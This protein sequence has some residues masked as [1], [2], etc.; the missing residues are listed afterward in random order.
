MSAFE[1]RQWLAPKS[2][3]GLVL[4]VAALC[5]IVG[6][7][8]TGHAQGPK[9]GQNK[10]NTPKPGVYLNGPL[11]YGRLVDVWAVDEFDNPT[12]IFK[13]KGNFFVEDPLYV[14]MVVGETAG[15]S[16]TLV[17]S[18]DPPVSLTLT[19]DNVS[20]VAVMIIGAQYEKSSKSRFQ[21]A[22][23]EIQNDA[24][25]VAIGGVNALPPYS[26]VP[27]DAAIVLNFDRALNP[28]SIGP[29]SIRFYVGNSTTTGSLPPSPFV[30]RYIWKPELPKQVIFNPSI[31]PIDDA[32]ITTEIDAFNLA[33]SKKANF[34][35][36]ILP[37]NP[38]GLP[39]SVA[40]TS[41]NVAVFIPAEYNITAGVTKILLA[42]DG[43]AIDTNKSLT[44]FNLSASGAGVDGILGVAR[45]FRSGGATDASQGFLSDPTVPELL[46]TQGITI[47]SVTSSQ[48]VGPNDSRQITF[49]YNNSSCDLSV[50]VGDSIQQ[51]NVFAQ[52]AQIFSDS[53]TDADPSYTV[54]VNYF[55][56]D[57]IF[58][59]IDPAIIT[60]PY[61]TGLASKS[62]CF[63]SI[64]PNPATVGPTVSGVDPQTT[65]TVRFSK[66]MDFS[67]VNPLR[68]FAITSNTAISTPTAA[69][70]FELI[71]G[72][73]IPS[74]DLKALK[75]VPYLPLPHTSGNT[76][77]YK[78]I[79][80]DGAKGVTDIVGN[81]LFLG[82]SGLNF[83]FALNSVAPSNSS[84]NFSLRF[85]SILE[86]A[87]PQL[88]VSGQVT[89]PSAQSIGPRPPAHFSRDADASNLMV[90]A[91]GA[92]AAGMTTPF[93]SLG[94]RLQTVYRNVDLNLDIGSINDIDLDVEGLAWAPFAGSL[95]T[96]D[97]F[98]HVRVDLAHSV[99]YPDELFSPVSGQMVFPTT[100]LLEQS[101]DANIFE[102]ID[103]LPVPVYEGVFSMN[104]NLLFTSQ[105]G[106]VYLPFPKFKN[107]Y[108][109]RDSSYGPQKFGAPFGNGVNP[110]QWFFLLGFAQ[111]PPA[112]FVTR[113]FGGGAVPSVGL[114][115]LVDLRI[116][117]ATDPNTKGLNGFLAMDAAA[118]VGPGIGKK[119]NFTVY[120]EGGLDANFSPHTVTP[121]VAPD[122]VVPM[123]GYFPPGSTQ[124]APGSRKPPGEANF[125]VGRL[126]FAVKMSRAVTHFYDMTSPIVTTPTYNANNVVLFPAVQPPGTSVILKVRGT[127]TATGPAI[128]DARCFDAYGILYTANAPVSQIPQPSVNGCG[129]GTA[130]SPVPA[131]NSSAAF[132]KD[133][134]QINGRK[135][136]QMQFE[137][138]S[139]IIN[140][141][142]PGVNAVGIAYK[143]AN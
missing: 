13:K 11:R 85:D 33:P 1:L 138:T 22:L 129:T 27:R 131:N 70:R 103:H 44:K 132:V 94:A 32:R 73:I 37:L 114:P 54:I 8:G 53:L 35:P 49:V 126:D 135:F 36:Q 62:S 97:F 7:A 95:N 3:H 46:G 41:F 2:A 140:N 30:G 130:G 136:L 64:S 119:P 29:D 25:T 67:K 96:S 92:P 57:A 105:S 108:T 16:K 89:K 81:T 59:A 139:D 10:D 127:D 75:F 15:V 39:A 40:T 116:Y 4:A 51:G 24:G 55:D 52:I 60:L 102:L 31:S 104:P 110:D 143:S 109:W 58:N 6:F 98:K 123:G 90:A 84:R 86:G 141:V 42:R 72:G 88:Q 124:G 43:T 14:D 20:G 117:P 100:G 9:A 48:Q 68:N 83:T 128:N 115:L 120:S 142:A 99:M 19:H 65:F 71:V 12:P 137:F 21:R 18:I 122:G 45:V 28:K 23:K 69:G 87:G 78:F 56:P 61:S 118:G 82:G 111:I 107:T 5:A 133:I 76:E 101:F 91:M 93:S 38:V 63:V 66:A 17:T 125:Y 26:A 121:D 134:T 77:N 50:R 47:Q 79:F 112:P 34:N 74:P 106:T 113:P 80:L